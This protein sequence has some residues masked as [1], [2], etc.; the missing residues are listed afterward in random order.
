LIWGPEYC[1]AIRAA[2]EYD[3][4]YCVTDPDPAAVIRAMREI[5]DNQ[6]IRDN[7]C[8]GASKAK[9]DKFNNES[10]YAVLKFGLGF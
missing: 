3:A 8:H 10:V 5:A 7:L 4:A 1:S 9:L 6:E 2:R